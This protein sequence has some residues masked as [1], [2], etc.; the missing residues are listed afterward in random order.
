MYSEGVIFNDYK[1]EV[2]NDESFQ[3]IPL[4]DEEAKHIAGFFTHPA[5]AIAKVYDLDD[6]A[7]DMI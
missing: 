2:A 7:I 3:D 4:S 1:S 5:L 6:T